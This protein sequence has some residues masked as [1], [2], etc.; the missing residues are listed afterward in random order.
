MVLERKANQIG[1][2]RYRPVC[3][4]YRF[5]GPAS[6]RHAEI[7]ALASARQKKPRQA[8]TDEWNEK[9]TCPRCRKTGMASLFQHDGNTSPSIEFVPAG[10]KVINAQF[11]S[12]FYCIDCD[13][14]VMP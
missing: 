11:G 2:N 14:E 12:T 5:L 1:R 7:W 9:L 6:D 8:M 3:Y 4:S 13:T 10:F